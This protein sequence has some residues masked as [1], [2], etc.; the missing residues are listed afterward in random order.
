MQVVDIAYNVASALTVLHA[1]Q[2]SHRDVKCANV[3]VSY[4]DI[5]AIK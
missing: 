4:I 3:F 2:I 5:F 1:K